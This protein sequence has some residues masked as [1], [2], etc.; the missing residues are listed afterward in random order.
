MALQ[1]AA[2]A[3]E[4][5]VAAVAGAAGAGCGKPKTLRNTACPNPGTLLSTDPAAT[6]ASAAAA[7]G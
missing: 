5:A 4:A 1:P 6:A 7:A 3:A 2:A